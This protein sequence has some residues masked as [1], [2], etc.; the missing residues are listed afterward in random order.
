MVTNADV[1]HIAGLLTLR[2]KTGFALYATPEILG[3]LDENRVFDVLD[4][5]RVTR[6]AILLDEPF[7]PLPDLVITPFAVPGKVAL[8]L[9][10]E[11][12]A[13]EEIGEQTVALML[14]Q[15][16]RSLAHRRAICA[17]LPDWLVGRLKGVD[18]LLFDG[19]VWENDDMACTGTGDKTG[20]RMGHVPMQGLQGSLARLASLPA[21]KLYIHVNNTN[22]VLQPLGPER[23]AL[24][25]AGWELAQDGQEITP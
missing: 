4:R 11:T 15:G 16:D 22:P 2:E 18:L 12:V 23:K 20:A 6:H 7:W 10:G 8:F 17:A 13:L 25:A 9:E 1:D 3:V 24:M 19:T 5:K 21:R 14:S